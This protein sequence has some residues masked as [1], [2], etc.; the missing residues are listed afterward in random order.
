MASVTNGSRTRW[1]D[2]GRSI[3]TSLMSTMMLWNCLTVRSYF[4]QV[5]PDDEN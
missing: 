1:R 4:E 2:F 5:C 3:R